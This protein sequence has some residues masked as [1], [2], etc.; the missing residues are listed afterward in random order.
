MEQ[1]AKAVARDKFKVLIQRSGG[2]WS[3]NTEKVVDDLIDAL[4]AAVLARMA[5]PGEQAEAV[6]QSIANLVK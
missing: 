3:T 1:D 2:Y 6:R 5:G 4:A